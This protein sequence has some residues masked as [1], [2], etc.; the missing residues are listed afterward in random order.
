M[1]G[2]TTRASRPKSK[3]RHKNSAVRMTSGTVC[4]PAS[5]K[6][7]ADTGRLRGR[8]G[9]P[10][11]GTQGYTADMPEQLRRYISTPAHLP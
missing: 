6:H 1:T 2:N 8:S 11:T 10:S 7:P 4:T 9:T 5:W 3:K